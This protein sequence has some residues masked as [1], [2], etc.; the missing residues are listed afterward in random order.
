[1]KRSQEVLKKRAIMKCSWEDSFSSVLGEEFAGETTRSTDSTT[2]KFMDSCHR[3]PIDAPISLC[4][5][6]RCF[7]VCI[8]LKEK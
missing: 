8:F 6:F 7:H 3:V 4:D 1:M 5:Q 2:E